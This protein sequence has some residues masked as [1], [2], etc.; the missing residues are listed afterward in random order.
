MRFLAD[1][2][3]S[4]RVVEWLRSNGH[5]VVHLREQK[6]FSLPDNEIFDRAINESRIILTF[7]LDFGEIVALSKSRKVSVIL[8]RLRNTTTPFV[9]KR[10]DTV[11]T[12]SAALL[13]ETHI[14]IIEE[15]RYRIR[16]FPDVYKK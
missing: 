1:M 16:K 3:I 8:F 15:N 4:M 11:M 12:E 10:L 9:I 5:D 2:G 14:V 7:D 13:E 6:L